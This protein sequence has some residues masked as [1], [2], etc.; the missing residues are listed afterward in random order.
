MTAYG[1]RADGR[2]VIRRNTGTLA[3]LGVTAK[4]NG[5]GRWQ[6]RAV[7]DGTLYGAGMHPSDFIAR[8][9]HAEPEA[10]DA[11]LGFTPEVEAL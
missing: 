4:R 3:L 6:Y 11:E 8:F 9:W 10:Y 2:F 1:I 5:Q 7:S